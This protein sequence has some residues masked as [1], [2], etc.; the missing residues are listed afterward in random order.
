MRYNRIQIEWQK[1]KMDQ[2][3]NIVN[4]KPSRKRFWC[5]VRKFLQQIGFWAR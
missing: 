3:N 4:K 2:M 1:Q 5:A